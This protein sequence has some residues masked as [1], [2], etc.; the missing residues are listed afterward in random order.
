[1]YNPRAGGWKRGYLL[2]RTEI[3]H[4]AQIFGRLEVFRKAGYLL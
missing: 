1:M 4:K 3:K 2:S